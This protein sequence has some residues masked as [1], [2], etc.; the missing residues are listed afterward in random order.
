MAKTRASIFNIISVEAV[1][2]A[3]RRHGP[4]LAALALAVVLPRAWALQGVDFVDYFTFADM[5]AHVVNADKLHGL[6]FQGDEAFFSRAP[7]QRALN[8][9]VRWPAGVYHVAL[10]WVH[11]FGPLSVWTTQLTNLIFLVLLLAGVVRLGAHLHSVRLGL[12][13]ALLTALCPPLLASTWYFSLDFP[14]V[15]MITAG[16]WGLWRTAGFTRWR[17][18]LV[19]GAISFLALYVKPT[20]ALYLVLPSL[21]TLVAGLRRD[22]ARLRV[23]GNLGLATALTLLGTGLLQG[24]ELA[25]R[26]DDLTS[27]L[28]EWQAP[29]NLRG[30]L[31]QGTP[32]SLAWF[33][34]IPRFVVVSFP[35]PLLL[36]TLPG[37]VRLHLPGAWSGEQGAAPASDALQT[38]RS[39]GWLLACFVWGTYLVFTLMTNKLERYV[40]P[41]YPVL[42][43]L[44]PWWVMTLVPRRW[45]TTALVWLVTAF[46]AT[47]WV[48][49]QQPTPWAWGLVP[50]RPTGS[51]EFRM[52][53]AEALDELRKNPYNAECPP[54]PLVD[55][56]AD[57]ARGSTRPLGILLMGEPDVTSSALTQ[58]TKEQLVLAASQR[59]RHRMVLHVPVMA[60]EP[61]PPDAVLLH[62]VDQR[63]TALVPG[64]RLVSKRVVTL[65]CSGDE[66]KVV[67]ASLLRR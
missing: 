58:M 54:G 30:E 7:V 50:A 61:L 18:C 42:C 47:S 22:G 48:V 11:L 49:H 37:L 29:E 6:Y 45:Q 21:W 26:W 4:L 2:G 65:R 44:G 66:R 20:Y 19:F 28:L 40:H 35:L 59:I 62:A 8:N 64:T 9:P 31:L 56:L 34:A 46:A 14:L 25:P 1:R 57:L 52:P 43:L 38:R 33:L 12:W 27:H 5:P 55:A 32:G 53:S 13:A 36:L 24:L 10:P 3:L 17:R 16:L 51:F 41:V 63:A 39:L 15:A 60:E 67:A 23:L